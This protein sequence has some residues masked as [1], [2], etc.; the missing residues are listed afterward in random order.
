MSIIASG[1]LSSFIMFILMWIATLIAIWL[2][3]QGRISVRRIP[4]LDVVEEAV[5]RAVEMG[6][7]VFDIIGMGDLHGTYGA[8]TVAGLSMLG[9]V[10][11]LCAKLGAHLIAPMA[12]PTVMPV[13]IEV[14]RDAYAAEG[15]LDELDVETQLPYLSGTQ[16]A[17]AS[18]VIGMAARLKPAANIMLGPFWAESMMFAES[19]ARAGAFQVGGVAR[20]YQI[21]FFAAVCDY[22]IIGE[23]IFAASAYVSKDPV[24]IGSLAAED[25]AKL[26]GVVLATIGA[27]ISIAGIEFITEL[28]TK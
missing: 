12:T 1:R 9:Y 2:G 14:V 18:G 13:A 5:G 20:L 4:G 27:I 19:F 22:V 11:G 7:P 25:F 26:V 3:K 23:E 15:K 28:L 10:A 17:W 24:M 6:K 21:P 8:Q 16:F